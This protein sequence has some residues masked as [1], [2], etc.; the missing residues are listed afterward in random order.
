MGLLGFPSHGISELLV[1]IGDDDDV[2]ALLFA[3]EAFKFTGGILDAREPGYFEFFLND[4]VNYAAINARRFDFIQGGGARPVAIGQ[5]V[6]EGGDS[7]LLL[8]STSFFAFATTEDT[9]DE[10][11]AIDWRARRTAANTVTIDD[12]A[13]GSADLVVSGSITCDLLAANTVIGAPKFQVG[14][15]ADWIE[16]GGTP[17]GVKYADKGSLCSDTANGE[18]YL[19]TTSFASNTGWK[20]VTHA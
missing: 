2:P 16:Y 10:L 8:G 17:E 4:G 9:F 1:T 13:G 7:G 14:G 6:L 15:L 18:L 12:G 3:R 19:K 5:D 11:A 20:L